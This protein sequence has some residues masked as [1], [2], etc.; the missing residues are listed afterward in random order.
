M[1]HQNGTVKEV[2]E[3]KPHYSEFVR[4]CLRY[5]VKTLEE[6]KGGCPV[7]RSEADRLNWGACYFVLKNYSLSDMEIITSLYQPSGDTL[8]DK[9]Y[10]LSKAVGVSQDSIWQLINFTERKIA[11]KRGLV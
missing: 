9:I 7:F 4:H 5:Y 3:L 11:Q 2:N 10:Q 6:G 1:R 8:P